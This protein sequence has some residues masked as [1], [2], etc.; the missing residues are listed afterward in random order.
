MG[1]TSGRWTYFPLKQTHPSAVAAI[2]VAAVEVRMEVTEG[3]D[4]WLSTGCY[5]APGHRL[6]VTRV[7]GEGSIEVQAG[8]GG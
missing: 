3:R 4:K 1:G 5:L 8:G 6:T 2:A 7:G